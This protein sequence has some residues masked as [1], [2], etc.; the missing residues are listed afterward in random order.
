MSVFPNCSTISP[1][2]LLKPFT[3]VLTLSLSTFDVF[4]P[5]DVSTQTPLEEFSSNPYLFK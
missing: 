1:A 3:K 5:S 2:N 4:L